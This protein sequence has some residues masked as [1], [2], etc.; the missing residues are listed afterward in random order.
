MIETIVLE[1]GIEYV[2]LEERLI[3]EVKYT[4]LSNINDDEDICFRKTVVKDGE[5]YFVGLDDEEEL[6][7]VMLYFTRENIKE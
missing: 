7:K 3:N 5:K 1:N 6:K 2:I 4:L